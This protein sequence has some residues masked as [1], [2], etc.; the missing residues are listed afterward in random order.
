[1]RVGIIGAGSM[2][3]V[4]ATGWRE[5]DAELVALYSKNRHRVELLTQLFDITPCS[6]IDDL[7]ERVDIVDI[8]TPTYTHPDLVRRAAVAGRH[9]LCEKPLALSYTEGEAML[10]CCQDNG[11]RMMVAHVLRFFPEYRQAQQMIVS[12]EYGTAPAVLRLYRHCFSPQVE[13]DNWFLDRSR[14]GGV[15]FDLALHDI[16]FSLWCAGEVHRVYAAYA[17]CDPE[18][19]KNEH[20]MIMLEHTNGTISHIE[21]SW[22]FPPP[23]FRM[24]F[25]IAFQEHLLT[26]DSLQSN[27]MTV[28]AERRR[29][30]TDEVPQPSSASPYSAEIAAFYGALV[31]ENPF[32]IEASEALEAVRIAEL[33]LK[34]AQ[35]GT[36][37]EVNGE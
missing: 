31:H 13:G 29:D 27:P 30:E 11:V 26:Y 17:R 10:K 1:M 34:A 36:V 22:A 8:C 12:G 5:T 15:G 3:R 21:G 6:T 19:A 37:Q 9:I 32:P 23:T 7:I 24:G 4:H 14:S 18:T 28:H 16:D 35:S 33:S 2:A 20:I 25:E